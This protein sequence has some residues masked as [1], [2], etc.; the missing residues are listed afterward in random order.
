M[1][2]PRRSVC[3]GFVY[4]SRCGQMCDLLGDGATVAVLFLFQ[5]SGPVQG[6]RRFCAPHD[7][8]AGIT[9]ATGRHLRSVGR[10]SPAGV[11]RAI[12]QQHIPVHPGHREALAAWSKR[13]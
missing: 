11:K 1:L 8:V 6:H 2:R 7:G 3:V 12:F 10:I 4:V 13:I 5:L 9:G